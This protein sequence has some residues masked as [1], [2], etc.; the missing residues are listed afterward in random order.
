VVQ[1]L[2]DATIG[3]K[4]GAMPVAYEGRMFTYSPEAQRITL[5]FVS[6]QLKNLYDTLVWNDGALFIAHHFLALFT[7]VSCFVFPAVMLLCPAVMLLCMQSY[8]A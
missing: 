6:Y 3:R 1:D 4:K 5:F 8:K 7:T 2:I